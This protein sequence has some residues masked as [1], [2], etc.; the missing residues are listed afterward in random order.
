MEE[1][2]KVKALI[3]AIL[4]GAFVLTL[5]GCHSSASEFEGTWRYNYN[6]AHTEYEEIIFDP[7][8]ADKYT[9]ND[10]Y[11]E[12]F[13]GNPDYEGCQRVNTETGTF[14]AQN[15]DWRNNL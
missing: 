15:G 4:C 6:D 9:K 8:F 12:E 14:F 10:V 5:N 2:M 1:S 11:T 3:F 13:A 7:S